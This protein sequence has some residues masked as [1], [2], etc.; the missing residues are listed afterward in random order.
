MARA[1]RPCMEPG[2]GRLTDKARCPEHALPRRI[3]K[4]PRRGGSGGAWETI[5]RRVHERE[6]GRCQVCGVETVLR[7]G[8]ATAERPLAHAHHIAAHAAGGGD[9]PDD[10]A[11]LCAPCHQARHA[12]R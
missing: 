2:C 3:P 1:P 11:L 8:E 5:R 4:N 10:L 12:A 7:R 9:H 6:N